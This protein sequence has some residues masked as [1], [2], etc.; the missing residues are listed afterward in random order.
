MLQSSRMTNLDAIVKE[1]QQ[2]RERLDMA[3]EA[4]T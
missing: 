3:I 1:L 4:L 2:Q